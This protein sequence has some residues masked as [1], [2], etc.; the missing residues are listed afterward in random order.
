[1][2]LTAMLKPAC[3]AFQRKRT[4][5]GLALTAK[6]LLI[7]KLTAI[8]LLAA[9]LTASAHGHSQKVS[10]RVKDAPIEE[11][12]RSLKKQTG[13][14]FVYANDVLTQAKPVNLSISNSTLDEVLLLL[15]KSQP[16]SYAVVDKVVVVKVSLV[17]PKENM[18]DEAV[19]LPPIEITGKVTTKEGEPL[20]GASVVIKRTGRGTQ[21]DANGNFK[22]TGVEAGDVLTISYTGYTQKT[23][24]VGDTKTIFLALEVASNELDHVVVQAYGTTTN[25]FN[26]GNIAKV[27]AAEI[28][29]QPVMNVLQALQGRVAGLNIT[30]TNGFASSPFKVELR[31]RNSLSSRLADPLYIVDGVPY[32]VGGGNFSQSE[33]LSLTVSGIEGPAIGQSPLFSI[34]PSDIES[35]EVLKDADA[36]AIYGSRASNGVILITTKKGKIGK[37]KLD[38]NVYQ[39]INKVT[40]YWKLLN[41][42]QYLEIRRES[43]VNEGLGSVLDDPA[44]DVFWPDIKIWDSTRNIDWQKEI[45]GGVGRST[46]VQLG[47]SGGDGKTQ[48][49][50]GG[51]Y[52]RSTDI[53]TVSGASQS[54]SFQFSLSNKITNNLRVNLITNY[55]Y[56]KLDYVN[57]PGDA[58]LLPPNA[59]PIFDSI[60]NLNWEGWKDMQSAFTF[61]SFKQKYDA[62]TNNLI[63]NI[64]LSY[65]I[66]RVLHLQTSLGYTDTRLDQVYKYPKSSRPPQS[67][68]SRFSD[69]GKNVIKNWT[70]EP[71]ITFNDHLGKGKLNVL[72]GASIQHNTTKGTSIRA[73]GFTTDALIGDM[74]AASSISVNADN[75]SAYR[76]AGLFGRINYNLLDKYIVNLSLRRDGSSRFGSDKQF[77]NFGAIGGAWIF[78]EESWMKNIHFLS[79]GKLRA[80]YGVTGGDGIGD[81]SYLSRW[82][83][84]APYQGTAALYPI[85]L[86][87]PDFHWETNKKL[88][89][90]IETGF[91]KDRVMF[92][93]SWYRN[94]CGNQLIDFRLPYLSGFGSVVNNS[95]ALVQN[96]G[97]E[98]TLTAKIFNRKKFKW[99]IVS[100]FSFNRNKLIAYPGLD[101][102]PF[103]ENLEIGK[104]ISLVRLLHNTGVDSLTGMYTYEDRTGNGTIGR[105]LGPNDDRFAYDLTPVFSGGLG[106]NF[107]IKN[108][109]ISA[110]FRVIKQSGINGFLASLKGPITSTNM[111]VEILSRWRKPGDITDIAKLALN[112]STSLS[113]LRYSDLM[114]SDAS[115]IRLQNLSISYSLGDGVL[116]RLKLTRVSFFLQGENVFI[117]PFTKYKGM[118][119]ETGNFGRGMPP[120]RALTM[121]IN[122][123]L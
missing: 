93:A 11:V 35:V 112:S 14:N 70:I 68:L 87:N 59:P 15:F 71:Q 113:N 39:G 77:G 123:S 45:Y 97:W 34:N 105:T 78:S 13:Y 8:L 85:Q 32:F 43:F 42:Q 120:M 101:Q 10:L 30:Q 72:I 44:F 46:N 2:D 107:E 79:Y 5:T 94:R 66:S 118:D 116:K 40:R 55:S 51:G 76:Y 61:G 17:S 73:T 88:E 60:G 41:T 6:L 62:Q 3:S 18:G 64:S 29:K 89:A 37:P 19:V 21:T 74:K 67:I 104:P 25:R 75:Y 84:T 54:G 53:L 100:N 108:F 24:K 20:A 52:S 99:T 36:T 1:M 80:S 111:P 9:G 121:G 83:G 26:T 117:I 57:L 22:L 82:Q 31:G 114:Y 69:F 92:S 106:N 90:A 56:N 28:E 86:N 98:Y 96:T 95:P 63:S 33:G 58:A 27:T 122:L 7:M 91:F 38:V 102:S 47:L 50:I 65:Q 115:F 4:S 81:Y 12:F 16:L 23:V 49:R 119:P 48:Y 110:F 103:R 109:T